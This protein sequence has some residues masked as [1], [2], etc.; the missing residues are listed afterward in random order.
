MTVLG[1]AKHW[2]NSALQRNRWWLTTPKK[3]PTDDLA[4]FVFVRCR[5]DSTRG[6]RPHSFAGANARLEASVG[7]GCPSTT[8]EPTRLR[9]VASLDSAKSL[10]ESKSRITQSNANADARG[11]TPAR[12]SRASRFCRIAAYRAVHHPRPTAR[13]AARRSPPPVRLGPR[14]ES[15]VGDGHPYGGASAH[16]PNRMTAPV[17]RSNALSS[18]QRGAGLVEP[19]PADDPS[20]DERSGSSLMFGMSTISTRRLSAR[21]CSV[22]FATAG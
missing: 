16:P 3:A 18:A 1:A 11:V 17:A 12:Q 19:A 7:D 4:S 22:S 20:S 5:G 13:H 2:T 10:V 9:G 8:S 15:H 14:I 6:R 21:F